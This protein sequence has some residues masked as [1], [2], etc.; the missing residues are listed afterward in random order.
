MGVAWIDDMNNKVEIWKR[1]LA[2]NKLK[3]QMEMWERLKRTQPKVRKLKAGWSIDE[4]QDINSIF[5]TDIENVLAKVMAEEINKE[6]LN[7]LKGQ[8]K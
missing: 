6:I 5:S 3:Q 1:R 4:M 2:K 7:S 8:F